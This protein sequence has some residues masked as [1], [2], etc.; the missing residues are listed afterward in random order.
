MVGGNDV[1]LDDRQVVHAAA[2]EVVLQDRLLVQHLRLRGGDVLL[3]GLHFGFGLDDVDG[4]DGAEIGLAL[5]VVVLAWCSGRGSA[6]S[7]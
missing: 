7:P 6:A 3:A 5:V 4:G 1:R 2:G